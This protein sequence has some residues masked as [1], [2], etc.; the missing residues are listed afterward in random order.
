MTLKEIMPG[1]RCIIEGLGK[2]S[3]LR[4]RIIDM[5]LTMGTEVFVKKYA[6]LG[7]PIEVTVRGYELT[8]RLQEASEIIVRRIADEH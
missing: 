7:D 1:Q 4:K 6:P 5:G 8:L 2:K 3:A